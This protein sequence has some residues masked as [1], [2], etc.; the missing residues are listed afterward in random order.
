[1]RKLALALALTL[2]ALVATASS[3]PADVI[4]SHLAA[5]TAE[6]PEPARE[7]LARIDTPQR[8]L[9]AA[10]SYAKAGEQL[11]ERWSWTAEQIRRYERSA[12]YSRLLAEVDAV[13]QAFEQQNPGY[14]LYVNLQVRTLELQIERWNSNPGVAKTANEL[15]GALQREL[16]AH[17][18]PV[19]ANAES[20]QRMKR[21]LVNWYPS[22]AAP[23]AAP[24]LSA[25]GQLRA[26]DFQVVR[27]EQVI[28][29]TSIA[30]VRRAWDQPGWRD[31]LQRAV[32]SVG[33][34]FV[35]PLRS[36]NE[37][38][39]YTYMPSVQQAGVRADCSAQRAC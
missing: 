2:H 39:H 18:Y 26:I 13:K 38:W 32:Q 27:G 37:P 20:T 35:G 23:L 5:L 19:R 28:A 3:G 17:R 30:S 1:M 11:V 16:S 10:R 22:T 8:K 15:Y 6:L 12:D 9:L 36:P 14:G 31:R 7:A 25:H 33:A 4:L 21:F 34:Q 29:G 24:G